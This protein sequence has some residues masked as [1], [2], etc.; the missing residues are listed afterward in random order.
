MTVQQGLLHSYFFFQCLLV[1]LKVDPALVVELF[2][3]IEAI[4]VEYW[5]WQLVNGWSE[6]LRA[7]IELDS[8]QKVANVELIFVESDRVS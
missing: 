4:T 2:Q 1:N 3:F 7:V 8:A 5:L 6:A